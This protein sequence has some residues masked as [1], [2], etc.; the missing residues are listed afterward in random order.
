MNTAFDRSFYPPAPVLR[1]QLSAPEEPATAEWLL[2]LVDT[3]SD[4]TLIPATYL[5]QIEALPLGEATI[6]SV[7]G[8][9][10][11]SQMYRVDLHF[12]QLVLPNVV[13]IADDQG[14]EALLGRNVL[15]KLILLLDG[16]ALQTDVLEARPRLH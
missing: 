15:N 7:L 10:R 5:N 8:Q 13:V 14:T 4:G 6:H 16:R 3:G 1:I 2:A 11:V 12:G 9:S